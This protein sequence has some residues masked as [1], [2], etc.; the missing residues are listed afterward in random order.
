MIT[1][2]G[3][4]FV[5]AANAQLLSR[6]HDILCYDKNSKV[7]TKYP[8]YKTTDNIS[9]ACKDSDT[10]II[11]V[12]T[13]GKD[14]RLDCSIVEDCILSILLFKIHPVI[15]IRSTVS[16]GFTE[17]MKKTYNGNINF[18]PEFL[19]EGNEYDKTNPSRIIAPSPEIAELFAACAENNP[20]ILI[21]SNSEAEAIKLFSNSFL[22]GRVALFNEIDSECVRRGFN[23]GKVIEGMC[24]DSRIGD[25]YNNPSFGFGGY[26]FP[27]DSQEVAT[28]AAGH[29]LRFI[30]ES[31]SARK[32][33][34]ADYIKRTCAGKR[35]GVYKIGMKAGSD[36]TRCSAMLDVIAMLNYDVN[37]YIDGDIQE[38][39]KN[40][41]VIICNRYESELD[42]FGGEIITRDI[43][44]RD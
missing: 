22:A 41:D 36:N 15:I 35:I 5:G 21:C 40:C 34:I 6:K 33:F 8:Q 18:V 28:F 32:K 39:F 17:R 11:C 2:I 4:G 29:L 31:N 44:R 12:P 10:Y 13:D 16:I 27:K 37:V 42:A 38:F 14:G 7:L 20:P 30:P 43:F 1:I 24:M 19:R 9:D 26:C 23:A 3:M 25:Y